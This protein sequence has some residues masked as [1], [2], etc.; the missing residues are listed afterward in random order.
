MKKNMK[1]V[2]ITN[3]AIENQIMSLLKKCDKYGVTRVNNLFKTDENEYLI[4]INRIR[5]E[6][7]ETH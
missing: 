4:E 6:L 3:K 5:D 1:Q 7:N 2:R